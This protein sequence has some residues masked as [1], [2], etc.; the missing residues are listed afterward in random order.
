LFERIDDSAGIKVKMLYASSKDAI[1][2]RLEGCAEL[3]G[4]SLDEME[5]EDMINKISANRSK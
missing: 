2:K 5:E 1:K 4:T 3:Q